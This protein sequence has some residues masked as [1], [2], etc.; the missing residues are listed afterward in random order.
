M[1]FASRNVTVGRS[2]DVDL[3]FPQSLIP[4][5]VYLDSTTDSSAEWCRSGGQPNSLLI[6]SD[7]DEFVS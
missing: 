7:W 1:R 4:G 6:W 5:E 3:D 2:S